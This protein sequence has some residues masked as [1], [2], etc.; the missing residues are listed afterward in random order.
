MEVLSFDK[1]VCQKLRGRIIMGPVDIIDLLPLFQQGFIH[2]LALNSLKEIERTLS[3]NIS[4]PLL[5]GEV[6]YTPIRIPKDGVW[7][8]IILE[9]N[10]LMVARNDVSF[11]RITREKHDIYIMLSK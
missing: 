5:F 3:S 9:R 1:E 8:D 7:S 2:K 4:D 6:E 11:S 10:F